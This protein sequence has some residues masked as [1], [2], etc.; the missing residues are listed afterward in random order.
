MKLALSTGLSPCDFIM[1]V[2]LSS[3]HASTPGMA[4]RRAN[5]AFAS[6]L[7]A[8][9]KEKSTNFLRADTEMMASVPS[10]MVLLMADCAMPM[11]SSRTT[12]LWKLPVPK[13]RCVHTFLSVE[14][15]LAHWNPMIGS[16]SSHKLRFVWTDE[17]AAGTLLLSTLQMHHL[18]GVVV[19]ARLQ[20][21]HGRHEKA[22]QRKQTPFS[23]I[24]GSA[25]LD[26]TGY[27]RG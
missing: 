11:C 1:A 14:R 24:V 22:R 15:P 2:N 19:S 20:Q 27:E 6:S 26:G 21:P 5:A 16:S 13:S 9:V 25:E 12:L 18:P 8:D 7:A 10:W 3:T 23:P 4:P 17:N